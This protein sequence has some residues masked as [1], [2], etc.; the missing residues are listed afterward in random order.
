[1]CQLA[2]DGIRPE[3]SRAMDPRDFQTE[4]SRL[5]DLKLVRRTDERGIPTSRASGLSGIDY[6][7][8]FDAFVR[9]LGLAPDRREFVLIR[10]L[11]VIREVLERES[12]GGDA[13]P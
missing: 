12:E 7:A 9:G 11:A 13:A 10:G 6:G 3:A 2:L 4:R 1:M 5:L 8:E